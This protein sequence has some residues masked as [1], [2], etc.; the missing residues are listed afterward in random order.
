MKGRNCPSSGRGGRLSE[1]NYGW[2]ILLAGLHGS[3]PTVMHGEGP[4]AWNGVEV[5]VDLNQGDCGDVLVSVG[6]HNSGASAQRF[7]IG[8]LW[9]LR[10]TV[11][12]MWKGH[13]P[14]TERPRH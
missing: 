14:L 12:T 10:L 13:T 9:T 7:G 11:M 6:L 5:T 3:G 1:T 4:I 8:F 2:T